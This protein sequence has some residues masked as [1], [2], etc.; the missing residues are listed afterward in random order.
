MEIDIKGFKELDLF[1]KTTII[2]IFIMMLFWYIS[3]YLFNKPFYNSSDFF[4]RIAFAFCLSV[5]LSLC[6]CMLSV[7]AGVI[8]KGIGNVDDFMK[9]YIYSLIVLMMCIYLNYTAHNKSFNIFLDDI[10]KYVL[11]IILSISVG[12]FSYKKWKIQL[13][14]DF[15]KENNSSGT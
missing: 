12:E 15:G 1:S 9:G 6:S 8:S 14:K 3:F 5:G 2:S 4:L 13:K 7:I 10:L 11:I